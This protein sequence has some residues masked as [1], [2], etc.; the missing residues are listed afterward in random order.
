MERYL[1]DPLVCTGR[2]RRK[3]R[4]KIKRRQRKAN[5][6]LTHFAH[7]QNNK[8]NQLTM[9]ER[10]LQYLCDAGRGPRWTRVASSVEGQGHQSVAAVP[11]TTAT[12]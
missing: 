5:K 12:K 4:N 2:R 8:H 10:M 1:Q 3:V 9:C 6:K 7:N 11:R